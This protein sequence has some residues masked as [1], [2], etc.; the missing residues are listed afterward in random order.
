MA[1]IIKFSAHNRRLTPTYSYPN[2][3][4]PNRQ[5]CFAGSIPNSDQQS[6]AV[7]FNNIGSLVPEA[8]PRSEM[9][10][11][12]LPKSMKYLTKSMHKKPG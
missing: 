2:P 12:K 1:A 6:N 3:S 5:H 10:F 4:M 11:I 9:M 7:F 8:S